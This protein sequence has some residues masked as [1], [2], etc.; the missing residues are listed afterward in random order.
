[1]HVQPGALWAYNPVGR[2]CG[3]V[4][5]PG[6]PVPLQVGEYDINRLSARV[7]VS[8]ITPARF[9]NAPCATTSKVSTSKTNGYM[10]LVMSA[11]SGVIISNAAE[12]S[13]QY[14]ISAPTIAA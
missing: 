13:S 1:M 14:N 5:D 10:V 3:R 9:G 8:G 6:A 4:L 7:S 11:F 2:V 12:P